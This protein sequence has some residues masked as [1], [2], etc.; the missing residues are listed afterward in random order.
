MTSDFSSV[1]DD[2]TALTQFCIR[3][4]KRPFV[5]GKIPH[6]F[7]G[8]GWQTRGWMKF[9]DAAACLQRGVTVSHANKTQPVTGIGFIVAKSTLDN[10]RPLGGD[11]DCCRNPETGTISPWATAFLT[12][13]QPFY[14]EVSPSKAG[15]RFFVW[16]NLPDD[17]DSVFG[18]GPQDDMTADD[19]AAILLAKPAAQKKIDEEEPVFNGLEIYGAGR[20]LSITGDNVAEYSYPSEDRTAAI[21][22]ALKP[23]LV[24]PAPSQKKKPSAGKVGSFPTLNI[25]DVIDTKGFTESGGQL[26]GTHPT[27]G[28]TSGINLVVNPS[29][30]VWSYMHDKPAGSAPGGDAWVW[31]ACEYGAVPWE[32]AGAGILT[33]PIVIAKIM[34]HA[35]TRGL[36]PETEDI[37]NA[38]RRAMDKQKPKGPTVIDAFK[39]ILEHEA[40]A[41]ADPAFNKWEWRMWRSQIIRAIESGA[42]SRDAEKKAHKFLKIYN[43]ILEKFGIDYYNLY[44]LAPV[45]PKSTKEEFTPEIKTK[46]QNILKTGDPVQYIAD[47]CGKL[48]L[49][50]EK[51]FKKLA[52]CISTQNI[53]S[54][55]GLHPKFTGDSSGDKTFTVYM[56]AHH[57]PKEAVIKGSMSAKAGFYHDDGNR[58]LRILDDYQAGNEDLDTVIKQT[59][60]EFHAPYEHRTVIKQVGATLQIGGEQTWAIT[61]VDSSQEIQVL[62]R[63]LPINVD[64]SV[65]LTVKVNNLTIKRY[66]QGESQYPITET[67]LVS[68][69]LL[70]ILR[71]EGYVDVRVP[72]EERIEWL[73][74]SNRRNPSIFMDLVIAHTA[75]FRHQREKDSEGYYLATDEDFLAARALFTDKDGEEL[76]KRLTKKERETLEFLVANQDGITQEDLAEKLKVSRQRAEQILFGQK[77][78]GGL[79]QKVPLKVE[80]ISMMTKLSHD[81]SQTVHKKLYSLKDYDRFAGFEGVVRLKPQ[82][83]NSCNPCKA[84]ASTLARAGTASKQSHASNVSNLTYPDYI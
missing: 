18:H 13:V 66:C 57:M 45:I 27:L 41:E 25:L 39:A 34:Q 79:D 40:V 24:E 83:S 70:Q 62:N 28:S 63:Q 3:V 67:V 84:D 7:T 2:L 44:P 31:L 73:D 1:H 82:A 9:D 65:D 43:K 12:Q 37:V 58:V 77:H 14:T 80:S 76:V 61:S 16:G 10:R 47:S 17:R 53:K 21:A 74:T 32:K 4:G 15:L 75:M 36:I 42:M 81:T 51:A 35:V 54:S 5:R 11:L 60:S 29:K 46:A 55:S 50:A 22:E 52:C 59:S 23:Y 68:R 48:V 33:D 26:S 49:G 19:R 6:S 30:G 20:H 8:S 69:C 71:D 56:F 78:T 64:D 38:F 72:F